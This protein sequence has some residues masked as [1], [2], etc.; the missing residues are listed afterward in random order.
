MTREEAEDANPAGLLVIRALCDHTVNAGNTGSCSLFS[1]G[2]P[3]RNFLRG[4]MGSLGLK[5]STHQALRFSTTVLAE[6]AQF[7]LL[8]SECLVEFR[9][10]WV[11]TISATFSSLWRLPG[12]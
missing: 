8:L 7:S 3:V 12:L 2:Q 10:I 1:G 4:G 6:S 11:L 5:L 9:V